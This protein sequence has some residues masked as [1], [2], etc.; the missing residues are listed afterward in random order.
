MV[1]R[2]KSRIIGWTSILGNSLD[3]I[4]QSIFNSMVMSGSTSKL[5]SEATNE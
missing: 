5:Y 3:M 2:W 1:T 4:L